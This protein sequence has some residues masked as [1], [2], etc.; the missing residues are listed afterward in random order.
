MIQVKHC[1]YRQ[2]QQ[3][4]TN[5][6]KSKYKAIS[7][8]VRS[9]TRKDTIS[10]VTNLSTSYFT[11]PKKFWSFLNSLKHRRHSI[12]PLKHNDVLI[13]EASIFNK[14]FYSVF[15]ADDCN[16]LSILY[17]SL[18]HH[19]DLIDS[20]EFSTEEVHAELSNLHPDKACGPDHISA[21]LLQKGANF[22]CPISH[23]VISIFSFNWNFA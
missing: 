2:M 15:T 21:Y 19:P 3:C 8:L 5:L 4:G 6:L 22:S 12:P 17:Q 1:I 20:V 18:I 9:Q 16:D 10:H 13:S 7:N 23:Q 14:Y 11:K